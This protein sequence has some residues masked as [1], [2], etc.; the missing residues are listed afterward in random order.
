MS[1]RDNLKAS[2][3]LKEKAAEEAEQ[4]A[5]EQIV[6]SKAIALEAA[7]KSFCDLLSEENI[8]E[9][10]EYHVEHARGA[11]KATVACFHNRAALILDPELT[12]PREIPLGVKFTVNSSVA[13][14]AVNS[15]EVL[16]AIASLKAEGL[17]VEAKPDVGGIVVITVDY[18]KL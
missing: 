18:S 13:S 16:L 15:D 2:I 1:L 7:K 14:E 9:I 8:Q 17:V 3:A 6:K 10:V 12:H 5:K 4:R 11:K